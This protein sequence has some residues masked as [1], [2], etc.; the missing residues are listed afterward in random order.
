MAKTKLLL[1]S[2]LKDID[3]EGLREV[4]DEYIHMLKANLFP[5]IADFSDTIAVIKYF[6]RKDELNPIKIGPYENI[7]P[8]E[9]ANRIAGDLVI[10]N[11]LLQMKEENNE[12]N[13]ATFTLR[14]GTTHIKEKGDFTIKLDGKEFEGEAFNV[15]E[16]FYKSKL[17]KTK[18]KW[19]KGG[20]DFILVNSDVVSANDI[21]VFKKI[22]IQLIP[23][24]LW[25]H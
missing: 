5:P 14:L 6:K 8:F 18:S 20:L 4:R 10:I 24:K 7:T 25:H 15:A 17:Y 16:S 13:R 19:K 9:A 23:V 1:K 3:I 12:L 2:N 22:N 21:E 11:G